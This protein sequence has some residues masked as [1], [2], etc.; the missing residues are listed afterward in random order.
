MT[1]LG[2]WKAQL[3]RTTPCDWKDSPVRYEL[4][5]SV[6]SIEIMEQGT[7]MLC[8]MQH[9]AGWDFKKLT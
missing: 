9:E 5:C 7:R 4:N 1:A 3:S 6:A 2:L 8:P